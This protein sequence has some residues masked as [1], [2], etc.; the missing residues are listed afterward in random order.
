MCA[1]PA[2]RSAKG[3]PVSGE[4]ARAPTIAVIVVLSPGARSIEQHALTLPVGSTVAQAVAAAG[5]AEALPDRE[6]GIWGRKTALDSVLHDGDRVELYRPL[7]V[8]PKRAR[9]E[10][11]GRQGARTA[12]LFAQRRPGSKPGY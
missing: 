12:G 9:R 11:F 5:W 2:A 6:T 10:R 7:K 1:N 8:D 4:G 3:R